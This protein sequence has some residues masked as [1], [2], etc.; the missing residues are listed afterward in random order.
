[1]AKYKP[2]YFK[3][4]GMNTAKHFMVG[5]VWPVS[6]SK[7][8][9]YNIELHPEGFDCSCPGFG[10]HGSC[11]HVKAVAETFTCEEVPEYKVA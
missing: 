4:A 1:M 11:K 3:P 2:R 9:T 5:I 7:G 8:N 6:G 10:F